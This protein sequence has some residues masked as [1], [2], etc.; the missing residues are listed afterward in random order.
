MSRSDDKDQKMF[1]AHEVDIV[2]P[3]WNICL[4]LE[5]ILKVRFGTIP[6]VIEVSVSENGDLDVRRTGLQVNHANDY[7]YSA[8]IDHPEHKIRITA[9]LCSIGED[10][11]IE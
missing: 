1:R 2:I 6:A 7:R 5:M 11:L 3:Q 8:V 10:Q 4:S 9:V